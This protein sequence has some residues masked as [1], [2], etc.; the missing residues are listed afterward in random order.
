MGAADADPSAPQ[1][2]TDLSGDWYVLIHY[3]DD[4]SKDKSITKFKDIVWS[5]QQTPNTMTWEEY[6]FVV[7]P[8]NVEL[9][10]RNAMQKH[11]PWEPDDRGWERIRQA[12]EV[13]SSAMIRKRLTGNPEE[14]YRSLAPL[15][16]GGF[17]QMTFT[18]NWRV[19]FEKAR[20]RIE[21]VDSLGAL[22]FEGMEGATV[23]EVTERVGAD[24]LRGRYDRETLHGTFRMVRA[25]ERRVVR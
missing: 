13:S 4:D 20:I 1:L 24:E 17:N 18:K 8:A 5:V 9:Y 15:E 12:V 10:R 16:V 19:R 6:P 14:G 11:L 25:K 21:V 3:K 22:G 23:Y 2:G 7:F